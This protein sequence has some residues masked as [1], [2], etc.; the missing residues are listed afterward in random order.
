[1]LP[2]LEAVQATKS[3]SLHASEQLDRALRRA[4]WSEGRCISMR[5]EILAVAKET[6]AVDAPALAA[7]LD[8]GSARGSVM[9][10]YHTAHTAEVL[11]SP[12]VFLYDGSNFANSGVRVHW[13]NGPFGVGFPV[14]DA[15]DPGI[16]T[17]ILTRAAEVAARA[18]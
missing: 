1:M 7:A 15:D 2:P 6:G 14:I 3:Q 17:D 4:F 9:A 13:Q 11:C 10:H 12:H 18:A 16:Y 5:H 8:S